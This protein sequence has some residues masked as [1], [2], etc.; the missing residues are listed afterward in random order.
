MKP[1]RNRRGFVLSVQFFWFVM[2][3]Q[4]LAGTAKLHCPGAGNSRG[5]GLATTLLE[6]ACENPQADFRG[7]PLR[8]RDAH[9]RKRAIRSAARQRPPR[10]AVSRVD[11]CFIENSV[12]Q[13]RDGGNAP[14]STGGSS[15]SSSTR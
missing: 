1:H 8:A 3:D 12:N 14:G 9:P 10:W 6:N 13:V 15:P 11:I 5:R 2:R 4:L 7:K